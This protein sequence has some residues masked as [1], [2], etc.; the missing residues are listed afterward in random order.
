MP[1]VIPKVNLEKPPLPTLW[2]DT[3]IIIKLTKIKKGEALQAI[4]IE[5]CTRLEKLVHDLVRAEK[6]LCPESDQEEE[7]V[8]ERLDDDVH[9]MFNSLSLGIS[10]VHRQGILD[11]HIFRGM[12]AY[13]SGSSTIDLPASAYFHGDPIRRLKELREQRFFVTVGP[14]KNPEMLR[15]RAAA[16]AE[17]G[18]R[19]EEL[20]QEFV[21]RGRT[22][23]EQ[24]ELEMTGYI[25]ALFE[26]VRTFE[27]NLSAGKIDF[28]DFMG[29][30]GA[31]LYRRCWTDLGGDPPGW[32]GVNKFF[33]SPYFGELPLPYIS[34]R[35]GA[36][37]LTGNEPIAPSDSMDVELLSVALPAA[38][39]VLTDR[40]MELR[41]KKLHLDEICRTEVYSMATIDGLFRQLE[42]LR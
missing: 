20:R 40:R 19:W 38:H 42:K 41:I 27:L 3:S 37:L 8:A 30:T 26:L 21:A 32:E 5:R 36:E 6:L 13:A 2:L 1:V 9:N 15:R 7:Y 39:Y 29:A 12:K 35:I 4:E 17:V 23:E 25:D 11:Q 22:Y 16:K 18:R 14:V 10:L 31:L 28:W 33:R 24:L 34:C